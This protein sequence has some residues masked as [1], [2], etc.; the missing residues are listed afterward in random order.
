MDIPEVL[1]EVA[2]VL[3]AQVEMELMVVHLE[4][5]AAAGV[6]VLMAV[7]L[8][9]MVEL[10]WAVQAGLQAVVMAEMLELME[11]MVLK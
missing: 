3:L 2:A 11:E 5:E 10:L 8:V 7:L 1:E 4:L 9:V 6:V